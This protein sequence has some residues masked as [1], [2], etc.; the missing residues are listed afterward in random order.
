MKDREPLNMPLKGQDLTILPIHVLFQ[1]AE[2]GIVLPNSSLPSAQF[3]T[4]L[5][6]GFVES[7]RQRGEIAY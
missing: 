7:L 3:G 2:I 5:L 6:I 1:D 4:E